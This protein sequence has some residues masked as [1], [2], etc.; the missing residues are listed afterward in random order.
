MPPPNYNYSTEF[1]LA[2]YTSGQF[3]M[4]VHG[5]VVVSLVAISSLTTSQAWK[6]SL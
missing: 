3:L 1:L 5:D 2:D 6:C 4:S